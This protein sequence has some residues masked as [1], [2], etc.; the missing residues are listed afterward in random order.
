[1]V[2]DARFVLGDRDGARRAAGHALGV[3]ADLGAAPAAETAALL[4]R[5]GVSDPTSGRRA[6]AGSPI[7]PS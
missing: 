7:R 5:I 2:V 3:L 1:M 6:V 4:R